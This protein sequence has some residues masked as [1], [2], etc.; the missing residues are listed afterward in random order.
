MLRK[1]ARAGD[2]AQLQAL[3][4]A[5][6][7]PNATHEKGISGWTALHSAAGE[8]EA[9]CTALLLQHAAAVDATDATGMT[10][11]HR[12][13]TGAHLECAR[14]LVGGGAVLEPP[15]LCE[16]R[17][18]PLHWAAMAGATDVASL[19]MGAGALPTYRDMHGALA[20]ECAD[21]GGHAE[22]AA[23]LREAE[24]AAQCE[25]TAEPGAAAAAAAAMA[26]VTDDD[27]DS[28]NAAAAAAQA[29]AELGRKRSW[30]PP[31]TTTAEGADGGGDGGKR[32]HLEGGDASA[33]AADLA[34]MEAAKA[35]LAG[36]QAALQ[37]A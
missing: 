26:M 30:G 31:S 2:A 15:F 27:S 22:C 36:R 20:S 12:A 10:A 35:A 24:L 4:E 5:G 6:R 11:L 23:V 32:A 14:L 3:L 8:G 28:A 13:A 29:A 34:A 18:T 19:L 9:T 7:N 17:R 16:E 21:S 1:A 33:G 25:A 37:G